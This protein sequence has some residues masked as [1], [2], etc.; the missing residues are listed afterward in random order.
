MDD[1]AVT[2]PED[3][4]EVGRVLGAWGIKGALRVQAF[5]ADPKALFSSKRWYLAAPE[6]RPG[7]AVRATPPA[8]RQTAATYPRLL[9]VRNAREQGEHIVAEIHDVTDRDAAEALKGARIH[10]PRS[11]FPTAQDDEFYWVDLIG[12]EVVNREGARL[13]AVTGLF[14]TGPHSV[15][16]V[17]DS[18]PGG[19]PVQRMIPFVAAYVDEV[20][21]AERRI[22]V[23]WGL[24]Y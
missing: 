16:Q 22:T 1:A 6:P 20:D 10:V 15:M 19:D 2:W 18:P 5:S 9:R 21:R 23:D 11:S 13:G 12:L 7:G 3:A 4:V 24:D 14:D 17:E 8:E